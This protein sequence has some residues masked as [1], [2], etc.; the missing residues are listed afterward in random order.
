MKKSLALLLALAVIA[1]VCCVS[2]AAL[3]D[4]YPLYV[5]TENGKTLN[6]REAPNTDA[7]VLQNIPFGD[8]FW[9]S[10]FLGNGWAYGH[11]GGEF[12]YV[13][14]RYLVTEK[15]THKPTPVP[16]KQDT[17]KTEKAKLASET[18]SEHDIEPTYIAV[19]ASR[20]SGWVN[21]RTGPGQIT[22]RITS[23]ADGKELIAYGETDN[24]YR[25]KD[26]DTGKTGYIHKNYATR[27]NKQ[28]AKSSTEADS[29]KK[30]GS[31]NVNGDFDL[32]CK[33]PKDYELQVVNIRGGKIVA[34]IL[35]ADITKPQLY[36]SIA[37]DDT[38][39]TVARLN[40]L[41]DEELAVLEG[42]FSSMNQVEIT[43]SQT[44]HG[45]KLLI[46]REIG[47]DTDFVDILTIY[48]GYFIEFNMTPNPNA[49][50]QTLS[51][52]QI[53][54]CVDFLTDLDFVPSK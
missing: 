42:S 11:W 4:S 33:L 41:T 29:E 23:F 24:W 6:L 40:D 32:T 14:S 30:L 16:A 7:K 5:Y 44:G 15:P 53:S 51:N 17:E 20:T 21:F 1:S 35:S 22:K 9:V 26:P 48:N 47:D 36:L 12:G 28:V 31:L 39:G 46:A 8:E 52:E 54:M 43:Y 37:Y 34:S 13:M 49:A 10:Y 45:T 18:K 27:L 19:R 50:N 3:A 25:A 38:Y 2:T